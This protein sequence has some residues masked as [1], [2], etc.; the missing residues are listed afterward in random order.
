M[1]KKEKE[2]PILAD[3]VLGKSEA[4]ILKYKVA[5]IVAIIVIVIG[6]IGFLVYQT[7]VSEP[8]EKAAQET[9]FYAQE[10]FN[11]GDFETALNGDGTHLGFLAI[12][13]KH[14][15][16]NAANIAEAYAGICY[17]QLG[18][19]DEAIKHL[20]AYNGKDQIIAP[21]MK[22]ALGNCYS[23][24]NNYEKAIS[25]LLEAAEEASNPAVTPYCWFDVAAMYVEQGKK[26]DAI[27]LYAKIKQEYP[28]TSVAEQAEVKLN[29]LK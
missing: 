23:H 7:W 26:A 25:L 21:Q 27:E 12:I 13:E 1:S 20:E 17:A 5:I 6:V 11:N 16:T 9:I 18:N 28:G 22:H 19:Y 29:S 10:S 3:E 14:S 8:K 2:T 24:K 4:F 15:G